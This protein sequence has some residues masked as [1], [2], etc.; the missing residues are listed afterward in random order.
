MGDRSGAVRAGVL[1]LVAA[2]LLCLV[3]HTLPCADEHALAGPV[4][5]VHDAGHCHDGGERHES[6]HPHNL[7]TP[8][9]P[10]GGGPGTPSLPAADP[11]V[12]DGVAYRP[13]GVVRDPAPAGG[14]DI[15]RSLC[16]LRR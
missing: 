1:T 10:D 15:L 11:V 7:V 13:V 12:A 6:A 8:R 2:L 4:Q 5:T 16:V 3:A 14:Q 9:V